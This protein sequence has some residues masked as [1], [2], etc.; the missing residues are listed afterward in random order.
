[1]IGALRRGDTVV[2]ASHNEGKVSELGELFAPIRHRL[3]VGGRLGLP[4]PEETGESF[5]ENA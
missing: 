3:R 4:E 5:D 1:M 2:I